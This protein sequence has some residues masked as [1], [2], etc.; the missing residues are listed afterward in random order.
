MTHNM[1]ISLDP[2]EKGNVEFS[3]RYAGG[4]SERISLGAYVY[5]IISYECGSTRYGLSYPKRSWTNPW[6]ITKSLSRYIYEP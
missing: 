2:R 5:F 6:F 4:D 1:C 3:P